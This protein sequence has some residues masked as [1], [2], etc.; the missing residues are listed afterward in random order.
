MTGDVICEAI[1][2]T[3]RRALLSRARRRAIA[4]VAASPPRSCFRFLDR[5][6]KRTEEVEPGRT[7]ETTQKRRAFTTEYIRVYGG[8]AAAV[9]NRPTWA[10]AACASLCWF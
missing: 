5:T 2:L 7:Q 6:F 3:V 1:V 8:R 9:R 4:A 10:A